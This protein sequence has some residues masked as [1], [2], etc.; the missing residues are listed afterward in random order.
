MAKPENMI[1]L[2]KAAPMLFALRDQ[3]VERLVEHLRIE[4]DQ[5]EGHDQTAEEIILLFS[6]EAFQ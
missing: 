4:G 1:E 5:I 6:S 3:I 2:T